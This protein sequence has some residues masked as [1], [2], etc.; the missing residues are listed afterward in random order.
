[1]V[2]QP[3]DVRRRRGLMPVLTNLLI[4]VQIDVQMDGRTAGAR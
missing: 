4:F 2:G 3:A 1:M